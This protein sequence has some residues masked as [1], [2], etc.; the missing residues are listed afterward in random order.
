LQISRRKKR[1]PFRCRHP[2]VCRAAKRGHLAF[3]PKKN[4]LNRLD[5]L[6][7]WP[8]PRRTFGGWFFLWWFALWRHG[9][10]SIFS[11]GTPKT[12]A[13]IADLLE[14]FRA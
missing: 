14:D 13:R 9:E 6:F 10:I 5:L 8:F 12:T 11:F 7:G 4:L 2:G 3:D 1:K